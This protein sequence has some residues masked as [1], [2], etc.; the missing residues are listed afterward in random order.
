[1][2]LAGIDLDT[3][4]T[5]LDLWIAA[6][7]AVAG[8]QEYEID[9]GGAGRRRLRRADA[10]EIMRMVAYWDRQVKALTSAAGGGKRRVTYIVPE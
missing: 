9:T 6:S 2:K 7:A 1:M 8:G 3:A 5:Q 4:Q 10:A